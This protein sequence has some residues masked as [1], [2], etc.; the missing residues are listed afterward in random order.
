MP[1]KKLPAWATSQIDDALREKLEFVVEENRVYRT[2]PD[3]HAPRR[4]PQDG[5]RKAPAQRGTPLGKFMG[6]VITIVQ[7]ECFK[8]TEISLGP[9]FSSTNFAGLHPGAVISYSP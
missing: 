5:E 6:E 2:L 7:L 1:W 9:P 8:E 4:R 3:R